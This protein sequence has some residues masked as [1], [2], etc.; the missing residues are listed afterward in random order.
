MP[1][2]LLAML[3][4]AVSAV[5]AEAV[6]RL[7]EE[8]PGLRSGKV[9]E[10]SGIAVSQRDPARLWIINDSDSSPSLHLA[11]TDG[12][13]FGSLELSGATNIDWED[14]VSFELDGK[15]RLLVADTGDNIARHRDR[16]LYL[17][18]EPPLPQDG[19]R[20]SGTVPI[21]REI[22]FRYEGGPRDCEAV[23]VDVAAR[24]IVLVSKR[25]DPP[26][27]HELPMDPPAKGGVQTTRRIGSLRVE[28]PGGSL[29]PFRNQP[30][31]MD[32]SADGSRAAVL[33]YYG[34]FLFERK[35]G[36]SWAE[37]FSRKPLVLAP[38]ALPQAEA[39]AFGDGTKSI[40]V[41]TEGPNPRLVSYRLKD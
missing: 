26:E 37:A 12:A 33:T 30:T 41:L 38:H 32:I 7:S 34:V 3:L 24:R 22:R 8:R 29:I 16:V 6:Y 13:D 21:L 19:G 39:L 35:P 18:D 40:H 11:G 20:L 28:A 9:R 5:H 14:L 23:A 27:V 25:T 10:A 31:A 17:L 1:M 2:R 4:G 36:E 15:P